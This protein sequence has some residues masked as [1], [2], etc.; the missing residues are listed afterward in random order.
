MESHSFEGKTKKS[1]EFFEGKIKDPMLLGDIKRAVA[2]NTDV[3]LFNI[4]SKASHKEGRDAIL[5]VFLKVLNELQGYSPD[6]PHIAHMERH[7]DE[8]GKFQAFKDAFHA[9]TQM[10]WVKERDAYEFNRDEVVQA[11][12]EATSQSKESSAKW[13]DNAESNFSLTIE[14]FCKWV[15]E[16]L[17]KKGPNHRL[18]FLVDEVGQFIGGD[19]HLMLNLQTITE[20]LGVTCKGRA[21]V[22]VTSQ[23]DIDA[24][25]GEMKTAR[26]NDFSKIQVRFRTRLSLSSANVD[27]VIQSRLLEKTD[28]AVPEL[29]AL[30]SSKGDIVKNQLTFTN[31]GMTFKSFKDADDFVRNYPFAPYQFQLMQKVFEAIRRAGATGLHLSRGE[32]SILDAFQSAAKAVGLSETAIPG[33]AVPVLPFHRE[34][35]RH[36]GQTNHR[37]GQGTKCRRVRHRNLEGAV[38]DPLCRRDQ[39]ECR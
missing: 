25:L 18:I 38:P 39:G 7:L 23:E 29:K 31:V 4:D 28:A 20:E 37:P 36:G 5:Q 19:S 9:A 8:K 3:M 35:P 1:V 34:F 33:A 22:V 24:V 14:S 16:Y 12:S 21:W 13:I 2:S 11:F 26:G 30:F 17:D 10:D 27:E 6:H 15:K 32:R